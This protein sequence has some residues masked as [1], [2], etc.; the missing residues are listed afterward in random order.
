M[1]DISIPTQ[2]LPGFSSRALL[3]NLKVTAAFM[4]YFLKLKFIFLG[5]VLTTE[6]N[7]FLEPTTFVDPLADASGCQR[8]LP[9]LKQLTVNVIRVYSVN[10]SLNHDECMNILSEAG[11]YTM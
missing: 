2:E 10:S 4:I 3:T 7:P 8:D 1:G 6:N 11:I 9:F 5:E